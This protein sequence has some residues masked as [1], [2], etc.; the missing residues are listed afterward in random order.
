MSVSIMS[1]ACLFKLNTSM[2]VVW[3]M[4]VYEIKHM[5]VSSMS[6]ACSLN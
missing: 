5:P 2:W 3:V 4:H 6:H 1:H